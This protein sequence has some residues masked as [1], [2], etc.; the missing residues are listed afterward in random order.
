MGIPA[1]SQNQEAAWLFIQW[2]TSKM[3][4]QMVVEAGGNP[5]RTSTLA[6]EELQAMRPE[7]PVVLE[8]LECADP[9]WRPLIP[10]WPAL[11][12]PILGEEISAALDRAKVHRRGDEYRQRAY[13]RGVGT[14]LATIVGPISRGIVH[15][16]L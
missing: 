10:E 4:D 12:A 13:P 5:M 7:F 1:N 15:I 2:F 11:N 3:G 16:D 14:R 9:D 8:Q 6:N